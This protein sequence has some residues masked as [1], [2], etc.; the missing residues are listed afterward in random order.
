MMYP[1]LS[2]SVTSAHLS[3]K[4]DKLERKAGLKLLGNYGD[5]FPSY[6]VGIGIQLD[7]LANRPAVVKGFVKAALKGL[8]FVHAHRAE[9]VYIMMRHMKTQNREMVEAMYDSSVPSFTKDGMI[10]L[11]AQQAIIAIAAQAI[12]RTEPVKP[13]TVFDFRV[14]REANRELEAEGWRP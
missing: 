4:H 14:V 1:V 3:P 5:A 11:E 10:G 6:I 2:G 13:D 8:K 12:G 7:A 9:T